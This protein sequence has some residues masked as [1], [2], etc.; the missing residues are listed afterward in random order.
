MKPKCLLVIV[1][2]TAVG[3]TDLAIRLAEYFHTEI[4]SADSRQLY[5]ELEIGTAKPSAAELARVRHHFVNTRSITE[6]YD[7]GTFGREAGET[8]AE[9]FKSHDVVVMCGG[10]GLYVKAVTE[11]FDDLPD[12]PDGIRE[13]ITEEFR[14]RGLEWLQQEVAAKDP[15]YFEEVDRQNPQRLMRA[16][17][18]IKATG[19]PFS[20]FRKNV[21]VDLPFNV[22]K[23]GLE[24]D[25]KELYERI[26]RRM[27]EM[28]HKGLFEEAERFFTLR[29]HHALQT[30][31][32]QEVYDFLEGVCDREEAIR[33]MK[34]NSRR[35][36]KRQLTWFRR[37]PEIQWFHPE[38]WKGILVK[39][40]HL[41][42]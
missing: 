37:D 15:D 6:D 29:H 38:D 11:G 34:R 20:G 3:K 23:I 24:R 22:V 33:L 35:Y 31:G 42:S 1:G 25:R 4:I 26:D 10:S 36:A 17:E 5:R 14:E 8:I 30:V 21:K 2:P 19:Q 16:L 39:A 18:V 32:Y 28:I 7:A 40:K 41:M 12:I 27:D 9:L 13:S